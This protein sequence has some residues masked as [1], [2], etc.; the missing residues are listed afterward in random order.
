MVAGR[1]SGG[2]DAHLERASN[3]LRPGDLK[4]LQLERDLD[5]ISQGSLPSSLVSSPM[6]LGRLSTFQVDSPPF[7]RKKGFLSQPPYSVG[8]ADREMLQQEGRP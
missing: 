1:A 3:H 2:A 8:R 6:K 7:F 5:T 4:A